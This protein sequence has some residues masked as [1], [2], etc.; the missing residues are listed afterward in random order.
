MT[1]QK[2]IKMSCWKV[3][4][5]SRLKVIKMYFHSNVPTER[6]TKSKKIVKNKQKYQPNDAGK[7]RKNF[8]KQAKKIK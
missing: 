5:M 6:I 1:R 7:Q 4:K 2:P 8:K 3:I